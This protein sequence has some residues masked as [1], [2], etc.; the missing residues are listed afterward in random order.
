MPA[1][2]GFRADDEQG[3]RSRPDPAGQQHEQG[4]IAPSEA[5]PLPGAA[6]DD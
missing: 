3:L 1:Q 4:A 6:Q 2:Q 5:G